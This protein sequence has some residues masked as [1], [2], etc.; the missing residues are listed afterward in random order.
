[1]LEKN[2]AN[3]GQ[4]LVNAETGQVKS[5]KNQMSGKPTSQASGFFNV[6]EAAFHCA[7]LT[8]NWW[9]DPH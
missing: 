1:M 3:V 9:I 6:T 8:L 7:K 4:V 5:S 2:Q